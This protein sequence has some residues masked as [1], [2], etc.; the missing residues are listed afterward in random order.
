MTP[1]FPTWPIA[2]MQCHLH[3]KLNA[4]NTENLI[5]L[6]SKTL[7]YFVQKVHTIYTW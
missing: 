4:W 2:E 3:M 5:S 1:I 7:E 6:I